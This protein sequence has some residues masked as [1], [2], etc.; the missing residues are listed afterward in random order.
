MYDVIV[1]G[2]RV[3]GSATAMLLARAG[4]HVLLV[5]KAAFPSETL[6]T[7]Q[8][9]LPGVARRPRVGCASIRVRLRWRAATRRSRGSTPCTARGDRSSTRS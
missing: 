3:A 4:L 7:H 8:V 9:Q 5:D 2:A 6:S 1:V